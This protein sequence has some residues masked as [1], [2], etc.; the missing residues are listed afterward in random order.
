M[1]GLTASYVPSA[2]T[3]TGPQL[4]STMKGYQPFCVFGFLVLAS[5]TMSQESLAADEGQTCSYDRDAMLALDENAFDQ[6]MNGG[7]RAL[8]RKPECW[9]A[10]ADLIRDYRVTKSSTSYILLWHEGQLR[11]FIGETRAALRL[12]E[13]SY[14]P[15]DEGISWN[16]YVDATVAFLK[17]DKKALVE[18][19][20][21]L[22][23]LPEPIAQQWIDAN[24][25][26]VDPLPWPP[27]LKVVDRL[28]TC[29]GRPY[30]VAY[31][32]CQ[33]N[34]ESEEGT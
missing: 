16:P 9:A 14:M 5:T 34:A 17:R 10:A 1:S 22:S 20:D 2:R 24:G 30:S 25:N 15:G 33:S 3:A 27:N 21:T 32:G 12:F 23:S 19:R 28:I 13:N 18:A 31:T 7:W 6:D 11:A 29:F 26:K 4:E 8:A